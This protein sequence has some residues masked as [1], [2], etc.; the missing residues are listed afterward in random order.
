MSCIS[1]TNSGWKAKSDIKMTYSTIGMY[2]LCSKSYVNGTFG[3]DIINLNPLEAK[4]IQKSPLS[5]YFWHL[6]D[7]FYDLIAK[8]HFHIQ[9]KCLHEYGSN[10][11]FKV[12]NIGWIEW[13]NMCF[14]M[15]NDM[16]TNFFGHKNNWIINSKVSTT[17]S[18]KSYSTAW[19]RSIMSNNA[20]SYLLYGAELLKNIYPITMESYQCVW[21]WMHYITDFE[22][23]F[24]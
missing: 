24:Q 20:K 12:S 10:M 4:Q 18:D 6:S 22:S 23:I 11:P 14:L 1:M 2:I 5:F 19:N 15:K 8:T 17:G 16:S 3:T 21:M 7:R 13:L 9:N